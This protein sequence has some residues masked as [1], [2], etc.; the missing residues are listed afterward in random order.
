[1]VAKADTLS[2]V[3]EM[4]TLQN[5]QGVGQ[6]TRIFIRYNWFAGASA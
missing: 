2:V 4:C 6:G 5:H 3:K 1:M